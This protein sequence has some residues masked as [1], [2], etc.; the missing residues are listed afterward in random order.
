LVQKTNQTMRR[1]AREGNVILIGRG[2]NFVTSGLRGGV[3]V[4]LVAPVEHRARYHAQRFALPVDQAREHNRRCD[5]ARRRYVATHFA[6]DVANPSAYDLVINTGQVTLTGAADMIVTY[7]R[8][9]S[10]VAA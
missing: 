1:L 3:H 6:T 8:L 4:R 7:L 10:P 9:M 5:A 2:A